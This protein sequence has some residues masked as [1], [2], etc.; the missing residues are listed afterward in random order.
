MKSCRNG[1]ISGQMGLKYL[2][3]DEACDVHRRSYTFTIQMLGQ[4][5][6]K[7]FI[8]W[9]RTR[10][11]NEIIQVVWSFIIHK[12]HASPQKLCYQ[13]TSKF[14]ISARIRT[15]KTNELNFSG[16]RIIEYKENWESETT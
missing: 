5:G 2:A 11:G 12:A 1:E 9:P 8:N 4:I 6:K 14:A 16:F 15:D 3:D 7:N 10:S 13:V